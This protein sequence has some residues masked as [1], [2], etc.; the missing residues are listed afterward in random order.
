MAVVAGSGRRA[1]R[2]ARGAAATRAGPRARRRAQAGALPRAARTRS[3]V[4]TA[5]ALRTRAGRRRPARTIVLAPGVYRGRRPFLNAHGHR[6][7]SARLG[8][9]GAARRAEPRWQRRTGRRARA[10]RRRSTS[11]IR[12][13][14]S[15]SAA[16]AVWGSG[17]GSRILDTTL[18]G[19]RASAAG[20]AARRPDGLRSCARRRAPVHRLRRARRRQRSRPRPAARAA[21]SSRTST[22]P[23][24]AAAIPGPRTAAPRRA[25]GSGTP[26]RCGACASASAHGWGSGP[27]PRR[28]RVDVRRDRRRPHARPAST[29]STSRATAR[30]GGCASGPASAS[31]S[32]PSG[33]TR[34]GDA[35][36]ASVGNVIEDSRFE[37]RL[38]GVYLDEGT[39]RTT[40]RSSTFVNQSVGGDR[41]LPRRRQRRLRERLPRHRQRGGRGQARPP[42]LVPGGMSMTAISGPA[43]SVETISSAERL[44]GARRRVGRPRARDAAPE[45]VPAAR[46]A[47]GVV[48]PLRRRRRAGAWTSSAATGGSWA[49]C[50]S[51]CAGARA[52]A[53][54]ASR[55]AASRGAA[56][57]PAR[58]RR[59][60]V[61]RRRLTESL[62]APAATSPTCTGSRP[63]AGSPRRSAR[64]ST[65]IERIEAPVLDLARGLGRRLPREDQ[66]EE[67]QPAPPP[68]PPARRARAS[69]RSTVA[70]AL[71]ELEPALEEA[72]RLHALRWEGR[73][74]GSG[75]A[76]RRR[77][78]L[79]PRR[80]AAARRDRRAADRHAAARRPRDRVPLLV[81]ARGAHVRA[82][83]GFRPCA[84]A[85]VARARQHARRDRGGGRRGAR[86]GSSSSAAASA[87]SSSSPTACEPLCHGFGVASGVAR[88]RLRGARTWRAIRT[89]LRLKR[90]PRLHR[91]YFDGLAPRGASRSRARAPSGRAPRARGER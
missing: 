67:A 13:G 62:A 25:S 56:R 14:R 78:A 69:S 80:A 10:R 24:S 33:P 91:L 29:S 61:R 42:E 36:P 53:S 60:R 40:V 37:S 79:P 45:P 17:R 63:A 7:Y 31:G 46:L 86:R 18:R 35:C 87:T 39:T 68:A 66:L 58:A 15:T 48:A 75:F 54:P 9:R 5:R 82:P 49:R 11:P 64:G 44:R 70:R 85:L 2:G 84:L 30:S 50:R 52:C 23:A 59:G 77:Q 57:P 4:S 43:T 89:R 38:A 1:P 83:A 20:V 32:P 16:I 34:T 19:H 76:T 88:A 22:S 51:S 65:L 6:I 90:S 47:R 71:D 28:T 12:A 41:R 8:A 74:D 26:R 81:R 27:A 3:R 72:F 73:P 21:R 55:A